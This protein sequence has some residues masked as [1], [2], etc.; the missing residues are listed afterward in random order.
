M[1]AF[2]TD[3]LQGTRSSSS[4]EHTCCCEGGYILLAGSGLMC[5]KGHHG[6]DLNVM[7]CCKIPITRCMRMARLNLYTDGF[8]LHWI[9]GSDSQEKIGIVLKTL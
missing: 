6:V 8:F 1:H 4:Q 3:S 9:S 7:S 2:L 5:C